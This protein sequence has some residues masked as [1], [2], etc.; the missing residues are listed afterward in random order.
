[1]ENQVNKPK[2][3]GATTDDRRV[4]VLRDIANACNDYNTRRDDAELLA[5]LSDGV[6]R[7]LPREPLQNLF[8]TYRC[9][10][11]QRSAP[12]Y[13]ILT[14][15]DHQNCPNE[16][17]IATW[18]VVASDRSRL[19][20]SASADAPVIGHFMQGNV[21]SERA[22][23][24]EWIRIEARNG[25]VGFMY[26]SLLEDFLA[27]PALASQADGTLSVSGIATAG[28]QG[29]IEA[30]FAAA[31]RNAVDVTAQSGHRGFALDTI[32]GSASIDLA[33]RRLIVR[34]DLLPDVS[35]D[36]LRERTI[37]T[38]SS[39]LIEA[40]LAAQPPLEQRVRHE[41]TADWLWQFYAS[42]VVGEPSRDGKP[43]KI[44]AVSAAGEI[45]PLGQAGLYGEWFI[46]E[47]SDPDAMLESA[48]RQATQA[49]SQG[50]RQIAFRI[51]AW[52][53]EKGGIAGRQQTHLLV[54]ARGVPEGDRQLLPPEPERAVAALRGLIEAQDW[55]KLA[56]HY[57]LSGS[58]FDPVELQ[59]G[60]FFYRYLP[61]L[62]GDAAGLLKY[63]HP[64]H[65]KAKL[66]EV[67]ATDNPEILKAT[68]MLE[69]EQGGDIPQRM[70]S[71][72]HMR[73]VSGG[74]LVLP[75]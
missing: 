8:E 9:L 10:P 13:A 70:L 60:A 2:Y 36:L 12:G 33:Q 75:D 63:R 48:L 56:Q 35:E 69:I 43:S 28:G 58:A 61:P 42:S 53:F 26:R 4:H 31:Q 71:S 34:L 37:N 41:A 14:I 29:L 17:E 15:L 23:S 32:S 6:T 72:F 22:R 25:V 44:Y 55:T 19:R 16:A 38:P 52:T 30:A 50:H 46:A 39:G 73:K 7:G 18:R 62:E 5:I 21:V 11:S 54:E 66:L 57:D 1:L 65:P 51:I 45:P 49:Y 27:A 20:A 64:F 67:A 24:G 59:S 47:G 40:V 68:M 74:L 3:H